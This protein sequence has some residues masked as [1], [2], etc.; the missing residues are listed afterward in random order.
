MPSRAITVLPQQPKLKPNIEKTPAI[1]TPTASNPAAEKL[2]KVLGKRKRLF[3][4]E[5][6]YMLYGFGD[7]QN[8]LPETVDL[9]EDLVFEYVYETTLKATQIAAKRGRLQTEDIVFLIRKDKKK[10]ARTIDS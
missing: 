10:Y 5:L 2:E 3:S 6:K 7:V 4:K 9:V 8:P 1:T